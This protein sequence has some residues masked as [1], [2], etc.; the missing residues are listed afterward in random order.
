MIKRG[1]TPKNGPT[2]EQNGQTFQRAEYDEV[3]VGSCVWVHTYDP[4]AGR[5]WLEGPYFVVD[6]IHEGRMSE[7]LRVFS[8][9]LGIER[10][11]RWGDTWVPIIDKV[12]TPRGFNE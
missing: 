6:K 1:P 8:T 7:Y 10:N 9:H 11:A 12:E 3:H 4:N 2:R 5:S